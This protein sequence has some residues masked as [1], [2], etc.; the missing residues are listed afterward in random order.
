MA[1][2]AKVGSIGCGGDCEDKTVKK[3]PLTSKNSN[4]ATGYLTPSAKQAF[5]QLRQA[6]TK[7]SIFQYFDPEFHIRIETNASGYVI[8][9][10]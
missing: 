2:D 3:S 1:K 8:G 7:A 10:V 9:G 5:I 4:R 6:F